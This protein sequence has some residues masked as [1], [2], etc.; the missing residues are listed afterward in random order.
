LDSALAAKLILEQGIEVEGINFISPFFGPNNAI[1][2][3]KE[4][5][6]P[7]K[8]EDISEEII[9][10][11]KNPK[12]GF[13]KNLNPCIDCHILMLRKAGEYMEKSGASFL[14]TGEVVGERP[15]SQSRWALKVVSRDSGFEDLIL[16]PLSAKLLPETLPERNK[17]VDRERLLSINGRT[18]KEQLVLA[19]RFKIKRYG[20][21]AG[22]CLLTDSF[23][24]NRLRDILKYNTLTVKSAYL[25]KTG[26]HFRLSPKSKAIIGRNKKENE[27]L[28]K[29]YTE[30]DLVLHVKAHKGPVG[31]LTGE[32]NQEDIVKASSLCAR[33][34]DAK[35]LEK[36]EV[37]LKGSSLKGGNA[38]CIVTP[39]DAKS[40]NV[41]ML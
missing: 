40:L 17:W 9:Q 8:I 41:L 15:K 26:R 13:G 2:L 18:R 37:L 28:L 14:V 25:L 12:Y 30:Q 10:I 22:G 29:S 35:N 21:P 34:S 4:L 27:I 33:Y 7:L 11:I 3:A 1:S 31:L 24:C 23:Y 36:V 39:K 19:E 32:W 20:S 38:T 5:N 16:R 6:I